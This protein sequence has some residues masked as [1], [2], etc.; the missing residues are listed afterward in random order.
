VKKLLAV[1]PRDESADLDAHLTYLKEL[2]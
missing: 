2:N 1:Y